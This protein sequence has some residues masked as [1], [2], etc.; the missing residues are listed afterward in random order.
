[1][2]APGHID[3]IRV[4]PAHLWGQESEALAV[5]YLRMFGD[6]RGFVARWH[7]SYRRQ[8]TQLL[9]RS[10]V[11]GDIELRSD[12][13]TSEP[14]AL[15]AARYM[16]ASLFRGWRFGTTNLGLGVTVAYQRMY[17]YSARGVWLTAGVRGNLMPKLAWGLVVSNLGVG[18]E[19]IQTRE[20]PGPRT[21][22]GLAWETPLWGSVLSLDMHYDGEYGLWR[23]VGWQ[24]AGDF[25]RVTAGVRWTEGA[26]LLAAGFQLTH[27][28]WQ[29]SYAYGYQ[30]KA[31]GQPQMLNLARLLN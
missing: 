24:S 4:N 20:S 27:R 15:F 18:E 17:D 7:G 2:A 26:P 10:M 6:L 11:E 23:S 13:P 8:P 5:G 12:I 14:L 25:F 9:L 30:N 22:A 28:S 1:M 31:L 3:L 29:V 21:S 19:L 16:S